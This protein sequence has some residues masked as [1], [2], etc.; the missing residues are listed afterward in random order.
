M[1]NGTTFEPVTIMK[2]LRVHSD[3]KLTWETH[4]TSII[5]KNLFYF[6]FGGIFIVI[7]LLKKIKIKLLINVQT[8]H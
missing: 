6:I 8:V 7:I 3:E 1:F 5:K 2:F 4:L